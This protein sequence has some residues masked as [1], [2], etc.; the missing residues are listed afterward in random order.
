M[1]S[2]AALLLAL[3]AP[4]D[5]AVVQ[6]RTTF[7]PVRQYPAAGARQ[8]MLLVTDG[9]PMLRLD[10]RSGPPFC[11]SGGASYWWITGVQDAAPV[12]A[13]GVTGKFAL[14]D[15]EVNDGAGTRAGEFTLRATKVKRLDGTPEYPIRTSEAIADLER[16][17]GEHRRALQP[18]IEASLEKSRRESVGDAKATGPRAESTLPYATWLPAEERLRVR[19]RTTLVDGTFQHAGGSQTRSPE[20]SRYGPE[21]GVEFGMSYELDKAGA[22]VKRERLAGEPFRRL[23]PTPPPELHPRF[24]APR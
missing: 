24:P 12:R 9:T 22:L 19:F 21:W 3:A 23:K 16:R 18:E 14:L 13:W 6:D 1:T 2:I 7:I 8:V 15:V 11:L 17:Y 5:E 4:Q 20:D 10:S